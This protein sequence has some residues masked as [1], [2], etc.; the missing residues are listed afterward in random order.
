M[1]ELYGEGQSHIP[2]LSGGWTGS[3]VG[4]VRLLPIIGYISGQE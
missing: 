1:S 4:Q 3:E 2:K